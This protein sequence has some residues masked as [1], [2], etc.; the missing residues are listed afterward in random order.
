MVHRPPAEAEPAAGRSA[1][2]TRYRLEVAAAPSLTPPVLDASQ[3]AVLDHPPGP[4]LVL[5]GPGT[6]KTTTLV[7]RAVQRIRAGTGVL[8][9]TFSRRAAAE[10][11][12]RIAAR[13]HHDQ[14]RAAT[15]TPVVLTFHAFCLA[16]VR[17]FGD[18]EVYGATIRLLTA[19]EQ[20]VRVRE[21][22]AGSREVA[23]PG[24]LDAARGTRS[25]AGEVRQIFARARQLGL[26]PEDLSELSEIG[27]EE[28]AGLPPQTWTALGQFFEEYLTVLD[29]AQ[30]LDYAEI[31]HR[32]R[33][34]L[35]DPQVLA[36][37][38]QE[39][40]AVLVD[41][42]ADTDPAQVAVLHQLA[43]EGRDL[44]VFADP[45]QSIYGFR[46]ADPQSVGT[47]ADTFA[48]PTADGPRPAPLMVLDRVH[49]Q[50]SRIA[51]AT[52]RVADRLPLPGG[53]DPWLLQRY[54]QPV[55][56]GPDGSVEVATFE[57]PGAEAEHLAD[58]L[59]RAHLEEGMAW[60]SMAV[61]VRSGRASIPGLARALAAAGVPIEVAGDEIGLAEEAAIRP[62]LLALT[63][64]ARG[65][66]ED[67]GLRLDADEAIRLLSSPL[68][69]LD[70]LALR[71]LGRR[72]RAGDA[73][74]PPRPSSELFREA[75]QRPAILDELAG[76]GAETDGARALARV[77]GRAA[78][79][80]AGG[81]SAELVAWEIWNGTDWPQRL[82]RTALLGGPR[83]ERADRDLDALCA[84]FDLAARS[85]EVTGLRGVTAF[86]AEVE[87]QQIPA[88]TSSEA[89]PRGSRVRLLTAHR[90][91]GWEWDLVVLAS[92]QEGGWP[93]LRRRGSLLEVDRLGRDR[94]GRSDLLPPQETR[95]RLAEERRLFLVACTRARRRLVV[96]A[97]AGTEG[98][99][100]QPSR[101]VTDLQVAVHQ[102][103]GRLR[104]PLT[105]PAVVGEL[106]RI[107]TDPAQSPTLRSAAAARLAR[108]ADETVDDRPVAPAADPA[109][110]W[111]MRP[112]TTAD[113]PVVA[114][115]Q[116]VRLS[117]SGVETLLG[118]PRRW[119]LQQQAR[120]GSPRRG[121]ATLGSV[122]HAIAEH[123]TEEHEL[124]DLLTQ[125]D[126]VWERISFDAAYR[127]EQERIEAEAAVE[128]MLAWQQAEPGTVLGVEVPFDLELT[129]PAPP[130]Q[131]DAG[132][133][134]VHLVGTVDRLELTPRGTVKVVDWKTGS[135]PVRPDRAE[136][137]DQLG[138][139]QLA[140]REGAFD[141]VTGGVREPD[142][143]VL[144]QLRLQDGDP[145]QPWPKVVGQSPL[146]PGPSWVHERLH[147]AARLVRE[148]R[149]DAVVND[150]CRFCD[151]AG[152]CPARGASGV[153]S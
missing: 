45:Q 146:P 5:A 97:V 119:F 23:W 139:Y 107:C 76:D 37:L 90:A 93:D 104:R 19:P 153:V 13:L 120:A 125:L 11:R 6:G 2:R 102:V 60:S 92:V 86:I 147:T 65:R 62:L 52:A 61:L 94:L 79:L 108:L 56:V 53:I 14:P 50:G 80:T 33:I 35:T 72:L 59:R 106:R 8:V 85:Q 148:E 43:G 9:L 49:R 141:A 69:G 89:D 73:V 38:R 63:V 143:A 150:A 58:L 82:R 122:V 34:L 133:E 4:L 99:A 27:A 127:T 121:A 110:W 42:Y 124:S 22:L 20:D 116:A 17:R 18:A 130:D 132:P 15:V 71:R 57:S 81:A 77:L 123:A 145:E 24:E 138:V 88:D 152:S 70:G 129:V 114:P 142:G 136:V 75:L 29:A 26:D 100:D 134:Q 10:L 113:T 36:A 1:H 140:V 39:F 117:P 40:E 149:F 95:A 137:H 68:G 151:F 118:C 28:D 101:F 144:V 84:F 91:K 74:D 25:F 83:A 30:V 3:Q 47:F 111:G 105:L 64:A 21:L 126:R 87:G 44:V 128:R 12:A 131:P 46:G 66:D 67:G 109:S 115:Q 51:T 31:V 96:T 98:E 54:R 78:E 41:E 7:E 135:T 16:V 48:S 103:S 32:C 112:L 55:P